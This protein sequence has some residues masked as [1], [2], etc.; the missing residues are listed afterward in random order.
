M[1]IQSVSSSLRGAACGLLAGGLVMWLATAAADDGAARLRLAALAE[2]GD[3]LLEELAELEPLRSRDRAEAQRLSTV[4]KKL[5]AEVMRVEKEVAAYNRAV[6]ELTA[7]AAAH[8]Q[9]CP[10]NVADS[11]VAECNERGARLMDRAADLD[12]RHTALQAEQSALNAQVDEHNRS[13][14]AW[15]AARRENAPRVDANA[16]DT[17][18]WVNVARGFMASD[19][20]AAFSQRAG[21]PAACNGLRLSDSGAHFGEE[22][23]KRLHACLKAVLRAL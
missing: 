11:A 19:E 16:A 13:R 7:S 15:L 8:A 21:R 3:L 6:A 4:Q 2:E 23:L 10:G 5:A 9:A 22:G 12:A 20:F 18:R 17:Q 1:W 14:E